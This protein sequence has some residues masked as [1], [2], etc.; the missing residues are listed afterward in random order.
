MYGSTAGVC[1]SG[2]NITLHKGGT[3]SGDRRVPGVRAIVGDWE[4]HSMADWHGYS[5]FTILLGVFR[6]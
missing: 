3:D 1:V 5:P 2:G 6:P 4:C